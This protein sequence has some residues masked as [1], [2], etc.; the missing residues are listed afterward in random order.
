MTHKKEVMDSLILFQIEPL[1]FRMEK[2]FSQK[3]NLL[4]STYLMFYLLCF[5]PFHILG[6]W[7]GLVKSNG[8]ESLSGATLPAYLQYSSLAICGMTSFGAT[9]LKASRQ[10]LR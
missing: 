10:L 9:K 2:L 7:T 5:L 3:C 8:F 4:V 1:L 6:L